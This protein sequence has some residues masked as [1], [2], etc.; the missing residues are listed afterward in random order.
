MAVGTM[1]VD[2]LGATGILGAT[3][4]VDGEVTV[5][6]G[7][8][9]IIIIITEATA[10]IAVGA[11]RTTL[12]TTVVMDRTDWAT[13]G[14]ATDIITTTQITTTATTIIRI[15]IRRITIMEAIRHTVRADLFAALWICFVYFAE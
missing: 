11:T 4:W 13:M 15:R 10:D 9:L 5:G 2:I 7:A 12:A 3:T 6:A 14:T 1:E 8:I